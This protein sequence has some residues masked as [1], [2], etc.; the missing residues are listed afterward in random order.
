[1]THPAGGG[2]INP[3][4][5][6]KVTINFKGTTTGS[7][8]LRIFT[9]LGELVH[10]ETKDSLAAGTFAWIPEDIASGIYIVSVKGPGIDIQ[11]KVA[12]LR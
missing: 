3:D 10:D 8:T 2:T 7:Y 6:E 4:R 5:G 1:M 11:K 12:I 9:L